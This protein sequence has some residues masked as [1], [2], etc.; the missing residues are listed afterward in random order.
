MISEQQ[1]IAEKFR[2]IGK[3][4]QAKIQG[5]TD[6]ELKTIQSETYRKVQDIRGQAEAEAIKIYAEAIGSNRE[7]YEFLRTSEAY[8]NG[9]REDTQ[10]VLSAESRFL[11]L[12]VNGM[13]RAG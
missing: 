4:E 9:L 1:R 13:G 6:L 3:G 11:Q 5:T 2:S 10:M 8:R 7:F 12:L